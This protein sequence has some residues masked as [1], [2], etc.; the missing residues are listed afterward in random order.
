MAEPLEPRGECRVVL[1]DGDARC[2]EYREHLE[3]AGVEVVA[4]TEDVREATRLVQG[5]RPRVVVLG[6][7]SFGV[8]AKLQLL[9]EWVG[10]IPRVAP[11][12]VVA[13]ADDSLYRMG[14]CLRHGARAYWLLGQ[15]GQQLVDAVL[16]VAD[17]RQR[18]PCELEERLV[19]MPQL[20]YLEHLSIILAAQGFVV[21]ELAEAMREATGEPIGSRQARRFQDRA[22]TKLEARTIAHAVAKVFQYGLWPSASGPWTWPDHGTSHQGPSP[23]AL[24]VSGQAPRVPTRD[25]AADM[26]RPTA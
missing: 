6:M 12:V 15:S 18:W 14:L 7:G 2:L 16:H 21:K 8:P 5:H 9:D 11:Q 1:V 25:R 19:K 17:G 10:A 4:E 3:R 24:L 23:P 13:S 20:R 26:R 22:R